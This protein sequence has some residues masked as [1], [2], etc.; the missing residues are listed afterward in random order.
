MPRAKCL[1]CDLSLTEEDKVINYDSC[2]DPFHL[3]ECSGLCASEVRAIVLQKRVLIFF[4]DECVSSFKIIPLLL[5]KISKLEN[6]VKTLKEDMKKLNE[7]T[8]L[9][10]QE[11][12]NEFQER[13]LRASNVMLYNVP[14]PVS[15]TLNDKIAEDKVKVA[16]VLNSVGIG[17]AEIVK[18]LREKLE[19]NLG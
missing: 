14:E 5:N 2:R 11:V 7:V 4:C 9:D 8:K 16:R 13:S 6:E 18:V 1:K 3:K 17:E 19:T 10:T 12:F 15:T